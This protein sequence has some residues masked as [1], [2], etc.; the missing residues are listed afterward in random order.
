M[1]AKTDK[2]PVDY[3]DPLIDTAERRFFFFTSASRPFGMVNLS[4]DTMTGTNWET[5]YRYDEKQI[6]WFSHVHAW[7]LCGIGVMPTMG[8]CRGAA[9]PEAFKSSF[10]HDREVVEPGYH[11]V[12]LDDY[13]IRAELTATT[14][15]G[16]HRYTF[17]DQG[18]AWVLVDIGSAIM[19]EMSDCSAK[20][21]SPNELVGYTEV[22]ATRRRPKATRIYFS[23]RCDRDFLEMKPW[24]NGEYCP[25]VTEVMGAGSGVGLRFKVQTGEQVQ[26][27]IAISYCSIKQAQLNLDKELPHWDFDRVHQ[28]ANDEWN[29]WLSRIEVEGG[30]EAQKTKFYTDVFH[31]LK[32]RRRV[33]DVN[34]AYCDMTSEEP[35][36]RQI[37]LDETGKPTYDHHNSDAFWGAA[38]SVNLLWGLAWPEV[39]HNFCNTF[40]DMYRN[41]GLIPRGP[42]GGN[43][44]FVM[45]APT[46]TSLFVSAWMQGVRT[47]D[48]DL[49]FEGLVKN[50]GPEGLM[51]KAGYEHDTFIGGGAKEYIENG[52]VPAGLKAK[53]FHGHGVASMTLEYAFYDWM[54]AQLAKAL[55]RDDVYAE[56][57]RRAENYKNVWDPQTRYMRPR[58]MDGNFLEPFDKDEGPGYAEG[59]AQ[60]YRWYAPHDVAGLTELFGGKETFIKALNALFEEAAPH[61][62]I[63]TGGFHQGP[64]D[65]GNQPCTYI[66][67]LFTLAG[68][69]WLTQKWVRRII[70]QAKSDITPYGG[71]GGDEDQGMMGALNAMM[72]IGLFSTSGMCGQDPHYQ[73]T[74]PIFDK[75]TITL[76]PEYHAG[77]TFTIETRG[78]GEGDRYIQSGTLNG[79][80]ISGPFL[81]HEDVAEGGHLVLNLSE[82]P[83]NGIS[84]G[85]GAG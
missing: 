23:I 84:S 6:Y 44:T 14:R 2:R 48:M 15:V 18:D 3:V 47:F 25:D 34:G 38:W 76:S 4:P 51:A 8:E 66:A 1:K 58:D 21:R 46:S 22:A 37:P 77:K 31:A 30:T 63:S 36:I 39:L 81:K 5:G 79:E 27:K 42:S 78:N 43:Y 55:G 74:T 19:L 24:Q 71:Y 9:G 62:F 59:T 56:M 73:L 54:L 45:T 68:A 69:P 32:G 82:T 49:A 7:Q 64:L 20:R 70:K 11:A 28:E 83:D 52:F 10:R 41:G 53:A 57:S 29:D 80:P 26:L 50:H 16:L 75:I 33:S 35:V 12:D 65:Y 60:H 85:E 13:H 72:S 61:N 17:G 67:H 40:L